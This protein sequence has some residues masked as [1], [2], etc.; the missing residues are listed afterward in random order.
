MA[1][2]ADVTYILTGSEKDCSLLEEA[3]RQ[4]MN[5][6]QASGWLGY[7]NCFIYPDQR[8]LYTFY[9]WTDDRENTVRYPFWDCRGTIEDIQPVCPL[10]DSV[11]RREGATHFVTLHCDE[12]WIAHSEIVH[13]FARKFNCHMNYMCIEPGGQIYEI[14]DPDH[15]F[16][17]KWFVNMNCTGEGEL[18]QDMSVEDLKVDPDQIWPAPFL[19]YLEENDI[20]LTESNLCE[21]IDEFDNYLQE[22][23][24]SGELYASA[25][26]FFHSS[27][28]DFD[29]EIP[30]LESV[31]EKNIQ[32]RE[33]KRERLQALDTNTSNNNNDTNA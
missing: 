18:Y 1:N 16:N 4:I 31:I 14:H 17:A 13:Y 2:N 24:E 23:D 10:D 20:E 15:V 28:D 29:D 25:G 19:Q 26:E 22:T 7:M 8:P 5:M 3:A 21:V 11:E 30:S 12:A 27:W 9:N 32:E 6:P 33:R